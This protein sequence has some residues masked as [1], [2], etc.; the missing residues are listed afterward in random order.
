MAKNLVVCHA[1]LPVN[2]QESAKAEE[3]EL[4]QLPDVVMVAGPCFRGVQQ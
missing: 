2:I 1:V 3:M 4:V